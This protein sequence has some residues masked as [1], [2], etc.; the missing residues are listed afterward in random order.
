MNKIILLLFSVLFITSCGKGPETVIVKSDTSDLFNEPDSSFSFTETENEED[1][2]QLKLGETSAIETLDP[3]FANSDS[4]RRMMKLIY[5]GLTQLDSLGKP[6]PALAKRWTVNADSTEFIFHLRTAIFFHDSPVFDNGVGRKFNAK[7]VRYVFERMASNQVPEL[8]AT[9]FLDIRGF[10]AFHNEQA[11]VKNPARRVIP[12]I[13]GLKIRND[14]TVVFVMNKSTNDLLERLAHPMASIYPR[15][16]VKNSAGPIQQAAGTGPYSFIKKE[17]NTHLLTSNTEYFG[18]SAKLN[19][20]DITS[21]LNERKLFQ[22]FAQ[23]NI[24]ALIEVNPFILQTIADSSGKLLNAYYRDYTLTKSTINTHYKMYYNHAS[25]QLTQVN[26]FMN[27]IKAEKLVNTKAWGGV[28]LVSLPSGL[29]DQNNSSQLIVTKSSHP[30]E[31]FLLDKLAEQATSNGFTF[32]MNA[33]YALADE[34][35]FSMQA[36]PKTSLI[37]EWNTPVYLLMHNSVKGIHLQAAPWSLQLS[38]LKMSGVNQ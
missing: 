17:E 8:T 4:E 16:S 29:E 12:T 25:G 19:R 18:K 21:G 38:D 1:F 5:D 37:L 26:K 27:S 13:E 6:V 9:H 30:T 15:E 34:V 11:Y 28:T 22:Q 31:R 32:S 20:L 2:R 36:F 23:Q 3:L 33:S 24:D 7:D 14:S 10:E 35:T